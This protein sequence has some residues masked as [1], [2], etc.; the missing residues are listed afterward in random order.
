MHF[1]FC[2]SKCRYCDFNSY[3]SKEYL[4]P[5][6][7]SALVKEMDYYKSRAGRGYE[8][9]SIYLGGGTP[10]L[11]EPGYISMIMDECR[12]AFSISSDAEITIEA[13]PG[14]LSLEKLKKYKECGINRLSIG[15]Q[16]W[17]DRHLS[18][19]GR[20]HTSGDFEENL[21]A[22]REAGFINISVDLI[23]GFPGQSLEDWEETL[24][25]VTNHGVEHLSCY[26]LKIEEG[27][28][29]YDDVKKGRVKAVDDE[30]DRD[31][32]H[33]AVKKLRDK[34]FIHYE[35]SNFSKPGFESRHNMN[36]WLAGEYIGL[37]A[38]THSYFQG[39]RYN[40]AEKPGDYMRRISREE[41][42]FENVQVISE[43]DKIS[44]YIMLGLRLTRGI[45]PEDFKR[46]FKAG[47]PELYG[48]SIDMLVEKGLLCF[49]EGRLKLTE[50]G[51]DLA[52]LVFVE[53]I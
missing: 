16:A 4:I 52:N 44:E 48:N 1:P 3:V 41:V 34:G 15:L 28:A 13:N 20:I 14:T 22:A 40:N 43:K 35:I 32:Y 21:L 39:K 26:S 42:L 6:Y 49:S 38:G 24:E 31:M 11:L 51:L 7:C 19:L 2:K 36:Y 33:L 45:D 25:R 27:T 29:L 47:L 18:S 12:K 17:Q 23:F 5:G 50:Q 37:G 46:K 9:A 8:I 53:F 30:L 10:S